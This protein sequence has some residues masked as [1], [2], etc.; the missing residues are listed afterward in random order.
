MSKSQ[1][2]WKIFLAVV[3]NDL[4]DSL[5]QLCMKKGLLHTGIDIVSLSTAWSFFYHNAS[6]VW[7]WLGIIAYTLNFFI[8]IQIL[9]RIELSVAMPVGSTSYVLI[10]IL[11][12]LFLHEKASLLQWLGIFLIAMGIHFVSKSPD[13]QSPAPAVL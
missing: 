10:P 12:L 8:W 5:A 13:P 3:A 2:T 4:V 7:L 11:A 1:L 6:S 9:S